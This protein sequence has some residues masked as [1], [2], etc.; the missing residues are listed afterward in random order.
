[1]TTPPIRRLLLDAAP[2]LDARALRSGTLAKAREIR[3]LRTQVNLSWRR[4]GEWL[5]IAPSTAM[6]LERQLDLQTVAAASAG[7]SSRR[8]A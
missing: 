6:Y 3:R 1:V 2:E 7:R 8:S 5:G 4:I